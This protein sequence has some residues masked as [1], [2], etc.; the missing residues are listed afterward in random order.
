M[1]EHLWVEKYRPKKISD[2]I[3]PKEISTALYD[4]ICSG[5]LQNMI[6]AGGAGVGKTTVARALCSELDV[7]YIFINASEEGGIDTLRTTIKNFASTVSLQGSTKC[8]ILDEADY[9][10]PQSTQPALR[11]FIEEH[12]A[13]CKFIFTCNFKNRII[14]PLHS[15][16]S[17]FD[18]SIPKAERADIAGGFFAR[19]KHILD[20]EKIQ[21]EASALADLIKKFF[22]DFRKV[23]NE[24][25][26][27]SMAGKIDKDILVNIKEARLTELVE[28]LRK[29]EFSNMRKWVFDNIDNDP[30][31]IYR[32]V[33]DHLIPYLNP[34]AVPAIIILLAD[35]QYKS[36]FVADQEINLVAC[37][38]EIMAEGAWK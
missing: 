29:K 36:A 3:L 1:E 4:M 17:V 32:A 12:S 22:P 24:C 5:S 23:I 35:Y 33:Y 16:C 10:N 34:S 2:C 15:R 19:L 31:K 11:S 20:S 7:D 13:N 18:F 26:R 27:Y 38:T 6:F 21:Y 37:L 28:H 8:V 30:Q 14:Q 25:Q 9:L